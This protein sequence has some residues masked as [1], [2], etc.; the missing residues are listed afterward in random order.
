MTLLS[1]SGLYK[2]NDWRQ[3][4]LLLPT[5]WRIHIGNLTMTSVAFTA[6]DYCKIC[7]VAIYINLMSFKFKCWAIAIWRR[8]ITWIV[9]KSDRTLSAVSWAV[10]R[11]KLSLLRLNTEAANNGRTSRLSKPNI[12][13]HKNNNWS[14]LRKPEKAWTSQGRATFN[15]NH[16]NISIIILNKE[17]LIWIVWFTVQCCY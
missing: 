15:L 3:R 11:C 16:S 10:T 5:F 1:Q 7:T 9:D 8:G 13:S 14:G 4:L 17:K 12:K 6:T 2:R